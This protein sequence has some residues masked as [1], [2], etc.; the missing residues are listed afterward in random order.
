VADLV[1]VRPR[2]PATRPIAGQTAAA[3]ILRP[4]AADAPKPEVWHPDAWFFRNTTGELRHA[5]NWLGNSM[6]QARLIAARRSA[7]GAEPEPLDESHPASQY[8]AQLAGGVGGQSSLLRSWGIYMMTPGVGYMYGFDPRDGGG[9]TWQVRSADE[10]RVSSRLGSDGRPM[11]EVQQSDLT[12]DWQPLDGGI[13]VRVHRPDPE[14]HWRPDSPVRGALTI[15]RELHTLTQAIEATAVSRLAGAGV[16]PIPSEITFPGGIDAFMEE[17]TRAVSRPIAD[18]ASAAAY[19][20]FMFQMKGELIDKLQHLTFSSPFDE[21]ALELRRELIERLATAMDMPSKALTGEDENHWGKAMTA[22]EGVRLHV[23]PNLELVCD[24]ITKGYL[25]PALVT[26]AQA[27]GAGLDLPDGGRILAEAIQTE[28]IVDDEGQ[29]IIC[30][31]DLANFTAKPD[32]S[33]DALSAYDRYEVS[34]DVMRAETGLSEAE[35]PDQD[36]VERRLLIKLAEGGGDPELQ[37]AA[38]IKL[39][40]LSADDIPAAPAPPGPEVTPPAEPKEQEPEVG[41]VPATS[42][43]DQ[44]PSERGNPTRPEPVRVAAGV[45]PAVVAVA[46]ALVFRAVERAGNR[47][48]NRLMRSTPGRRLPPD[49]DH[50]PHLMHTTGNIERML[51]HAVD[52][53]LDGAWDRLPEVAVHV[54]ACPD[55][56]TATLHDY[57]RHLLSTRTPHSWELLAAYMAAA[58]TMSPAEQVLATLG[59]AS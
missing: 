26:Q 27:E 55:A 33:D 19:V 5:E 36:E 42:P 35:A 52:D 56:L 12:T 32:R 14:R 29:Q 6:G 7:P 49:L 2:R 45:D 30:W 58:P 57:T 44:A 10:I 22:D 39:G 54:G 15:L 40:V 46:D 3:K 1:R 47:I 21:H 25:L 24:G 43:S 17:I 48:R 28:D 16:F 18:R 53:L 59:R 50:A 13:V 8:I 38:V 34:G 11:Y 31:Y 51:G 20:P 9:Y 37:R 23:Q 41:P 4:T